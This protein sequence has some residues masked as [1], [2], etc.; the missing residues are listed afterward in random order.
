MSWRFLFRFRNTESKLLSK[1]A[2]G[3]MLILKLCNVIVVVV[4]INLC[5]FLSRLAFTFFPITASIHILFFVFTS[6][7]FLHCQHTHSFLCLDFRF[8]PITASIHI[9][10]FV[11]TSGFFLSLPAH[12]FFSLSLLPVF[13]DAP[14]AFLKMF[15]GNEQWVSLLHA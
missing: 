10:F 7:F 9:L 5:S 13:S 3:Y 11:F 8:F 6:G 14:C 1:N 15:C 4:S 2:T 12:K